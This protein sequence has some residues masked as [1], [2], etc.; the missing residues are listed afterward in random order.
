MGQYGEAADD[1]EF[2][3]TGGAELLLRTSRFRSDAR[4]LRSAPGRR[5]I[6]GVMG[7]DEYHDAA[8]A[9]LERSEPEKGEGVPRALQVPFHDGVI[10]QSEGY[11]KL[12]EFDRREYRRRYEDIWRLDRILEGEGE[13]DT[14]NRYRASKQAEVLM[15]GYLSSPAE[16]QGLFR[17]PGHELDEATWR[18]TV[19]R[20]PHR[21]SH[22]STLSG[23]VHG[24]APGRDRRAE[25]WTFCQEALSGDIAG[26]QGGTT[27][28]D[29]HLG[30]MAGTLG[31]VRRGLPGLETRNGGLRLD[32]VPRPELSSYGF[33]LCSR[34]H[35]GI[36]LRLERGRVE[37]AVPSSESGPLGVC[38][39]DRAAR[40][41]PGETG[42]LPLMG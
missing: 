25:A 7:P 39:P 15:L 13:G 2:L 6:K 18:L 14:V 32:P 4:R 29:V 3:H 30:A 20:Y 19:D 17:R 12:A 16:P 8:E 40:L 21:T 10:S 9:G 33:P 38:L 11:G 24:W 41:Q 27:G 23:L 34:G 26:V 42:H 5:R 28:E 37:I 31:L 36:R 1:T 22:G 35:R